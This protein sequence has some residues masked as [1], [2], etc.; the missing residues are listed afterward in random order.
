MKTIF[1]V[2]STVIHGVK[3]FDEMN[4][5]TVS[6]CYNDASLVNIYFSN[7]NLNTNTIVYYTKLIMQEAIGSEDE[8]HI[9]NQETGKNQNVNGTAAARKH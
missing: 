9:S 4:L 1:L 6:V 8:R 3:T 5:Q 2:K 7:N